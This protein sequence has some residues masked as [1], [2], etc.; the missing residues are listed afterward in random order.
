[1]RTFY[2]T[3]MNRLYALCLLISVLSI[4]I[5]TIL[6]AIGVF[7]RYVLG[8]GAFYAEPISIFLAIQLSFYGA[9]ACYRANAH[10]SLEVL[11]NLLPGRGRFIADYLV[12][13]L[14]GVISAFM[15]YY[16]IKLVEAT[17]FQTYPEFQFIRV[18]LVYTAIP[19][20]GLFTFLFVVEKMLTHVPATQGE[21]G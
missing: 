9:A 18:G 4:V 7:S 5:M 2:I 8:I 13:T 1:M 6:I 17:F 16:G 3:L 21:P 10:L 19:I 14:M 11:I 12:H 15:V 20:A